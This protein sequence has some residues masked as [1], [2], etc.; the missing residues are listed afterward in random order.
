MQRIIEKKHF[1]LPKVV[2]QQ[3]M[4]EVSKF[5]TFQC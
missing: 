4:G 1:V 3:Y 5:I 2:R